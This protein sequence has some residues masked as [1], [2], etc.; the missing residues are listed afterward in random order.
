[1]VSVGVVAE[2]K[3]P[4]RTGSRSP[5]SHLQTRDE[6]N[7]W[8]KDHLAP[9]ADGQYYLT[10]EYTHQRAIAPRLDSC[11]SGDAFSS[12]DPVFSSA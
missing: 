1:M 8:I 11:S 9:P 7:L 5:G 3:Y 6:Q 10:S 4:A 12:C 2:G